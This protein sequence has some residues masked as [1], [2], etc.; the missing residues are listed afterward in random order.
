MRTL[1][2]FCVLGAVIAAHPSAAADLKAPVLKA[3]PASYNWAGL[4]IGAHGG[5]GWARNEWIDITD[6]A[7]ILYEGAPVA[8]G[9]LIGGQI[10]WNVQAGMWVYGVE[11]D[12]AWAQLKSNRIS[13]AFP[14]DIDH[15]TVN[16]I[17]TAAAR[18]GYAFNNLLV[19]AKAGGAYTHTDYS[20]TDIPSGVNYAKFDQNHWGWMVGA[21]VEYGFLPDWSLKA[22]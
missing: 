14:T 22:E 2:A 17:A 4:Y 6:P 5:G 21:G 9:G 1:F 3:P 12:G 15:S 8:T 13:N 10:G 7:N 16:A 18:L 11:V 19:Y 20:I